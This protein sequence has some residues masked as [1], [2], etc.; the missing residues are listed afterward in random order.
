[1][2]NKFENFVNKCIM[3]IFGVVKL[4]FLISV[5]EKK[6]YMSCLIEFFVFE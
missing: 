2:V 6:F 4:K 3:I 1:M 5:V